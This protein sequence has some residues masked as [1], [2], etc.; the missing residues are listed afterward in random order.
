MS[1][2]QRAKMRFGFKSFTQQTYTTALKPLKVLKVQEKWLG[3]MLFVL[4]KLLGY[5]FPVL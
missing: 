1:S 4:Q 3:Y 5:I 2:N